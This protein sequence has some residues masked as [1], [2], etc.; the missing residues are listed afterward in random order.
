[1][2]EELL[3]ELENEYE[4]QRIRNEQEEAMRKERIRLEQPEIYALVRQREEMIFGTLRNILSGSAQVTDLPEK[5]ERVSSS[6]RTKL[7]EKGFP[8]D[9]L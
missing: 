7:T 4:Q 1:M 3:L 5:M 9:Y 6:I 2:R 8:D